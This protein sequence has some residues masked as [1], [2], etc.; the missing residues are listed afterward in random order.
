MKIF[1]IIAAAV[2]VIVLQLV[3][4]KR[5]AGKLEADVYPDVDAAEP[6]EKFHIILKIQNRSKV[7]YPFIRFGIMIPKEMTVYTSLRCAS[8]PPASVEVTGT[9]FLWPGKTLEKRIEVSA[10]SR[11]NYRFGNFYVSAGDF[12]GLKEYKREFVKYSSVAVYP[13]PLA[14]AQFEE[15][16]GSTMGDFSV[17]RY[18]FEDPVLISGFREYTGREPM[19]TISWLQSARSGQL[20]VKKYDFT[21]EV[22]ISV[23]LDSDCNTDENFDML[24][25]VFS[26]A[27]SVCDALEEKGIEYD[28]FMNS[29]IGGANCRQHYFAKG[30]GS[31][32]EKGILR[33]LAMATDSCDYTGSELAA[34]VSESHDRTP[35]IIFISSERSKERDELI[36]KFMEN[37]S[38]TV[39]ALYA[40]D[41]AGSVDSGETAS[42]EKEAV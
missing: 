7:V 20:M 30:M 36:A 21:S 42:R 1:I 15:T 14:D 31:R 13:L 28:F 2:I 41:Y 8:R 11:G 32:H 35:G 6:G 17:R 12:L 3:L 33:Q 25:R 39:N 38:V 27:R 26:L 37:P 23:V 22:A 19:K 5:Q 16:L 9:A 24:E 40:E 18:I 29:N 34:K 10:P 4:Q